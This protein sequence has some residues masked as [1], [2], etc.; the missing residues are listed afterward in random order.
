MSPFT[1]VIYSSQQFVE[2]YFPIILMRKEINPDVD[3]YYLNRGFRIQAE[4]RVEKVS[5]SFDF[6]L[7][8]SIHP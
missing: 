5:R 4:G 7:L 3:Q 2:G 1:D 8:P 6:N